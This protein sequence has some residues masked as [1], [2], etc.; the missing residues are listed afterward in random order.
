MTFDYIYRYLLPFSG[1]SKV[2]F[3][4]MKGIPAKYDPGLCT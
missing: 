2:T 3:N 4:I 1:G